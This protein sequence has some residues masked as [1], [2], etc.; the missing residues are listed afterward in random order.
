[1]LQLFLHLYIQQPTTKKKEPEEIVQSKAIWL[2]FSR[3]FKMQVVVWYSC[4]VW[5]DRKIDKKARRKTIK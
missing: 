3:H 5:D 2:N 1:M 4:V